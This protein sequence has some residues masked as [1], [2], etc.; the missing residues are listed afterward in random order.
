MQKGTLY[1]IFTLFIY[2]IYYSYKMNYFKGA[3]KSYVMHC[4]CVVMILFNKGLYKSA[5]ST[6]SFAKL[7][8]LQI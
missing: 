6:Y 7:H 4:L 5:V 8:I 2:Y 3:T 1:Y